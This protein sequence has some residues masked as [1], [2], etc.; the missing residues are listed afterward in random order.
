VAWAAQ[1]TGDRI[2]AHTHEFFVEESCSSW[3]FNYQQAG[4]MVVGMVFFPRDKK[5][6]TPVGSFKEGY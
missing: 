6:L 4:I 5:V 1:R 3:P 2:I